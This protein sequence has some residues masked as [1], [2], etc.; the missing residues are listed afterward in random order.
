MESQTLSPTTH[1]VQDLIDRVKYLAADNPNNYVLGEEIRK[2]IV[3]YNTPKLATYWFYAIVPDPPKLEEDYYNEVLAIALRNI[4]QE[5]C[6]GKIRSLTKELWTKPGHTL[7][8][9]I[10]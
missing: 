9:S 3:Q 5:A 2:Y 10:K 8:Y 4:T 6:G 7:V 1:F